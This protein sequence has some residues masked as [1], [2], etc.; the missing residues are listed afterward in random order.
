MNRELVYRFLCRGKK[1]PTDDWVIGII[2]PMLTPRQ[3]EASETLLWSYDDN[4]LHMVDDKTICRSTGLYCKSGLIFENDEVKYTNT[5]G[6]AI[7]TKVAWDERKA[8]FTALYAGGKS[9]WPLSDAL[10]AH[11]DT[12]EIVGSGAEAATAANL[13]RIILQNNMVEIVLQTAEER[14]EKK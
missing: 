11:R 9:E 13:E 8:T 14:E 7:S 12:F 5:Y 6:F 3:D 10:A 4:A 1:N 2:C